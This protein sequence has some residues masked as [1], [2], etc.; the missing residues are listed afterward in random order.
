[1]SHQTNNPTVKDTKASTDLISADN[2]TDNLLKNFLQEKPIVRKIQSCLTPCRLCTG[3]YIDS[4]SGKM[5]RI[6]CQH[7]CHMSS[8]ILS[9]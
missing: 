3:L 4:L 7:Q 8:R 1:M 6:I 2:N 5:L 9:D